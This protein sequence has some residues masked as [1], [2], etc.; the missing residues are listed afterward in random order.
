MLFKQQHTMSER[1]NSANRLLFGVCKWL[2][3]ETSPLAKNTR[4][5]VHLPNILLLLASAT[6]TN[7][8]STRATAWG[9]EGN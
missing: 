8:K 1:H 9:L 5:M 2:S 6:T 3:A 7:Q 4:L